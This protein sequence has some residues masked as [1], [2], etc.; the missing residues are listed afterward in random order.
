MCCMITHFLYNACFVV[1]FICNIDMLIT[2]IDSFVCF[3]IAT[4]LVI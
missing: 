3:N 2:L 4:L 1:I